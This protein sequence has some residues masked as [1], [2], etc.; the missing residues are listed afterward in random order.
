MIFMKNLWAT[1]EDELSR[2]PS[3]VPI[4][5]QLTFKKFNTVVTLTRADIHV[6]LVHPF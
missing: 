6:T 4:V 3:G 2:R 1:L 5:P